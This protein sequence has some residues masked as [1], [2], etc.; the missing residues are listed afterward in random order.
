[1]DTIEKLLREIGK[2]INSK[3][4]KHNCPNKKMNHILNKY[5]KEIDSFKNTNNVCDNFW[6]FKT[7]KV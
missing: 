4:V 3:H 7:K 6:N 2:D 5:Q 1:M